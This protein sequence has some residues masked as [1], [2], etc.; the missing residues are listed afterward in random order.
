MVPSDIMIGKEQVII[1]AYADDIVLVGKNEVEI[2][3]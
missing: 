3:K 1:W 2:Q